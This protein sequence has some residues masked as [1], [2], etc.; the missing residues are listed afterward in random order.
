MTETLHALIDGLPA[1]QADDWRALADKALRG[2]DFDATLIRKTADGI[3]R[4]PVF[5]S[6]ER[7]GNAAPQRA[8]AHLPWQIRQIFT[9]ANP[10]IAN[11]AILADLMGGVSEIGLRI[12][13]DGASGIAINE[14]DD[15]AAVLDGV[16]TT[17]APAFLEPGHD[18]DAEGFAA[19]MKASG[20]PVAGLALDAADPSL[21]ELAKAHP[22]YRIA[23][24]DARAIHE[25]G[26]TEAQELALAA[27][28]YAEAIGRLMEA[29]VTVEQATAQ[30]E[31]ILAADA[32]IHLTIS[33]IRAGY[34]LAL[35]ILEAYGATKAKPQLRAV[36]SGRMMTRQDP[37][38]NMIRTSAAGF[39]AAA[40][41]VSV[42]TV[43]P[44]TY[45]LGRPDRLAR[46]A[47]RNLQILLQEEAHIGAVADPAAGSN[48]H[49]HLT[50]ALAERAWR[51]FQSIESDGG[52][53]ALSE[54]STFTQDVTAARQALQKQYESGERVLFGINRYAAPD[55]REMK[56]D[57]GQLPPSSLS[58]FPAIRL[59]DA[60][61]AGAN[62]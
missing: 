40:A 37:W 13:S 30:V 51:L 11:A 21:A 23:S 61:M 5:F 35:N 54:S 62:S 42:L 44:A 1:A 36:T 60:A 50:Q 15:L 7:T 38:T 28:G 46:R 31:I 4:G 17:I 26:G 25:T 53:S 59:E 57:A 2:A 41:G 32:D 9:E 20:A 27:A 56:F 18:F 16:D 29:D 52:Y 55:L 19:W 47:A 14:V 43:L 8:D 22:S 34:L 58:L 45:A 39:A 10:S 6:A 49:E 3:A 24:V 33:K 48:L 12:D